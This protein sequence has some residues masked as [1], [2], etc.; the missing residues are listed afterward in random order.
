MPASVPCVLLTCESVCVSR[1]WYVADC[2][3]GLLSPGPR[4]WERLQPVIKSLF[5]APLCLA[6]NFL[7][8]SNLG[9]KRRKTLSPPPPPHRGPSLA[10]EQPPD[11]GGLPRAG[12]GI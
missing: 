12:K 6:R 11:G 2:E 4:S 5:E 7:N 8:F 10:Q 3:F 9:F 1:R